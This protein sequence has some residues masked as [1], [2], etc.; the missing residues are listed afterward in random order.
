MKE[1]PGKSEGQQQLWVP[2]FSLVALKIG[3]TGK[4]KKVLSPRKHNKTKGHSA[5]VI[6]STAK[7]VLNIFRAHP[8]FN[9][10]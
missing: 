4:T 2:H 7:M 10:M 5:V 9:I 3:T 6:H 1:A 8:L